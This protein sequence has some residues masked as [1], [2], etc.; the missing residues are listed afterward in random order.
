ML[1]AI[2]KTTGVK[3]T[4]ILLAIVILQ[5]AC[6]KDVKICN[7]YTQLTDTKNLVDLA[8]INNI[9]EFLDTLH[10]YP[11]LQVAKIN[12]DQYSTVMFC[13]VF[14]KGLK[15]FTD[16]YTLIKDRYGITTYDTIVDTINV[17]L[18][19]TIDFKAAISIARKNM[20]YDKTCIS[21][22]LGLYNLDAG[23]SFVYTKNYKLV[24]LVQGENGYPY[25]YLDANN[26]NVYS[27]FDGID[28]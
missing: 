19:P 17:S 22:R 8:P 24:W 26:G 18:T 23:Q 14:Y 1:V 27:K 10:K 21:Y 12:V 5:N 16:G 13:N 7:S 25:V 9:P 11:N 2:F 3:K 6:K 4:I 20:N 28:Y 15:V